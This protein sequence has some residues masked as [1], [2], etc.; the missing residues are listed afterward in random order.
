MSFNNPGSFSCGLTVSS[1][2]ITVGMM[3]GVLPLKAH[4]SPLNFICHFTTGCPEVL[5]RFAAVGLS[6]QLS[7]TSNHH[8]LPTCPHFHI[9]DED[10]EQHRPLR[11]SPPNSPGHPSTAET[12]HP[13]LACVVSV[14]KPLNFSWL[15]TLLKSF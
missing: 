7:V 14:F 11:R 2:P 12:D 4:L 10:A 15:L 5:L 8:H 3:L 6:E 9:V 13:C 1:E